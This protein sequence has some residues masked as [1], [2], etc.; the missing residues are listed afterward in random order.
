[1]L[2]TALSILLFALVLGAPSASAGK[3]ATAP[4]SHVV[5]EGQTLARIA[6]R[7]SV[8]IEALCEANGIR[9]GTKIK[10]G[11]R[12]T[13]PGTTD[14]KGANESAPPS[15]KHADPGGKLSAVETEPRWHVVY[16]GQTLGKIAKRYNVS[17]AALC[18][19]NDLHPHDAI[20]PQQ[21]LIIP[22]PNDEDGA[23]ARSI[24]MTHADPSSSPPDKRRAAP[25]YREFVRAPRHKGYVTLE[26]GSESF[27][28]YVVGP[29]NRVIPAAVDNISDVLASW[30]TGKQVPIDRR[31]ILLIAQVS[32]MFGGRPIRVVSGFRE[33]SFSAHSRHPQGRALD[34]SIGDV[35]NWAIRDYL[36]TLSAVG[37]GYYPNSTFVHMD[38]REEK[39]YWVDRAG[40]GEAPKY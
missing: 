16:S 31:L 21:K 3:G 5:S 37:V 11:L 29:R 13:I 2:R 30:R 17:I 35:P 39:T 38:V 19:A 20:V 7:Y 6:K 14:K 12:L 26:S 9:P 27:R 8:S 18:N 23:A 36:R 40:P 24:R 25:D 1:M 15:V 22:S 32:D 4:A 28:G 34:F 33:H 10:P